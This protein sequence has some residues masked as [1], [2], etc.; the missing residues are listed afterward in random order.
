MMAAVGNGQYVV[1]PR[2]V[3]QIQDYNNA[4]VQTIPQEEVSRLNIDPHYLNV[5]RRGLKEV[6]NSGRG[7]G[8]AAGHKKISVSGKTGTGQWKPAYQQNIGWFAGYAPADYPIFSFAVVYE[9][10]PGETVG[11]GKNAA[12]VVGEFLEEYLTE[13]HIAEI[14]QAS[15]E[16]KIAMADIEPTRSLGDDGGSIFRDSAVEDQ[17]QAGTDQMAPEPPRQVAVEEGGISRWLKKLR[18][19]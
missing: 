10:D 13:D 5:V 2:L 6:V 4:V 11:G 18:K 12:P 14:K 16:V 9:G 3:K 1:K 8:R 19:R 15:D 7:T 17:Y